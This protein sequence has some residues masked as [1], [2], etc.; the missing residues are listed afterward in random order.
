MQANALNESATGPY[1]VNSLRID[2]GADPMAGSVTWDPA[3]SLW[4]AGMLL[5]ALVFAPRYFTWGA[6]AVFVVLLEL[7]MCTGHSV[8]FH[9]LLIH[10][11]FKT[12]KWLERT[13]VWSGTL[14]GMQGPFWVIQSHD[15]RDWAQRQPDCHPYLRHGQ[16]M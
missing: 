12:P 4:N 11:T 3:R 13:L 9:R 5:T 16:G 1:K 10:R 14:V 7:T 6:F 8:G 2:P 15:F